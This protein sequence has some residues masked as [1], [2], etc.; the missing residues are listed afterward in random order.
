MPKQYIFALGVTL[1]SV[2]SVGKS[3]SIRAPMFKGFPVVN[4]PTMYLF[5]FLQASQSREIERSAGNKGHMVRH[6]QFNC[7]HHIPLLQPASAG[8][9]HGVGGIRP[10]QW[11]KRRI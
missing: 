4:V 7:K 10:H 5:K 8:M 2:L 6:A 9:R 1:N 11:S 3:T